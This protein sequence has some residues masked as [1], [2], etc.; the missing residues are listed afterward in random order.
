MEQALAAEKRE[1]PQAVPGTRRSQ[2]Y[3]LTQEEFAEAKD[4]IQRVVAVS[5][6]E[7]PHAIPALNDVMEEHHNLRAWYEATRPIME[8]LAHYSPT[9]QQLVAEWTESEEDSDVERA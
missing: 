2:M 1:K 3:V 4:V 6:E 5:S 9:A 7:F 8:V